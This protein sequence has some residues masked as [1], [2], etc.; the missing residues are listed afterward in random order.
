LLKVIITL[1]GLIGAVLFLGGCWLFYNQVLQGRKQ[2]DAEILGAELESYQQTDEGTTTTMYRSKYEVS[3]SAEGRLFRRPL[4]GNFGSSRS[5]SIAARLRKNP[6][7]SRR[8]VYYLPGQPENIVI[9]PLARRFGFAL[10][11]LSIG[12]TVV[13]VAGLLYYTAQPLEW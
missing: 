1:T 5:E 2:A 10:L 7:G 8:P 3:Y 6:V 4:K 9:D 13:A 12:A 11:F